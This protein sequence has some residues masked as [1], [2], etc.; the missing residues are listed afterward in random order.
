MSDK[1]QTIDDYKRLALKL[2]PL[3]SHEQDAIVKHLI[4]TDLFFL[5][6]FGCGRADICRQWLLDRCKEVQANPDE[7]LDLWAREHYKDVWIDEL[8]ATPTGFK[9]HGDLCVGDWVYGGDGEPVKVIALSERFTDSECY[10]VTFDDG[11]SVVCGGNHLWEVEKRTRKRKGKG[12]LYREKV[13]LNTKQ[14]ESHGFEADNRLAVKVAPP[15]LNIEH[16]L[17]VDPYV[18]G[19]W[20]GDGHTQAGR[21]TTEDTEVW[22]EVEQAGY[23]TGGTITRGKA[24]TKTC[25]GLSK[26]LREVGV[27]GDKHIPR[28]YLWANERQRRHLLQGLMDSDGHCNTRGTATFVNQNKR[29]I[30]DFEVLC[31]SLGLK[32]RVRKYQGEKKP[33]WQ[34][35]FQAYRNEAPFRL[36]R[37]LDRCKAGKREAKRFIVNVER[38][39]T[40]ET[41]CIQ[42]DAK[43]GLYLV[44]RG[45][46]P[47]HNSTVITFGLTIQEILN[48]PEVT[49]GIFSHSRPIAKGF[50]RQVKRELEANLMLK[51]LFDDVLFQT[52]QKESPKWSE[53]EG[54]VVK[55]K[56]NPKEATLEAWGL[57]DGQPIGKHYKLM[58]YDD[59]VTPASV[60]TPEMIEKTTDAWAMSRSLSTEGG[61]TRYIGTR[62]HFNDTYRVMMMRQSVA[63]RIYPATHD[64]LPD[65]NPVLMSREELA[66]RRRDQGAY[67]F[68]SQMLL[69]PLADETQGF[70]RDWLRYHEGVKDNGGNRYILVDAASGKKKSSDYTAIIVIELGEDN[71]YKVIDLV[72]DRLSLTQRCDLVT[73]FVKKYKPLVVG[74]E[75]YGLMA[76]TEYLRTI[77][78][79]DNYYYSVVE[80][81]GQ[82]PKNDRISRLVPIFEQG[83]MYLPPSR[84]YTG[85]DGI[86][87]DMVETFISEEYEAFPVPLHDDLLD[88]L[89][90]IVDEDLGATFPQS[91]VTDSYDYKPTRRGSAWTA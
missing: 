33:F 35:S 78:S 59:V 75:K 23:A 37:K 42:V 67:V 18:L 89:S 16:I 56:G 9:S 27:F 26:A 85:Y 38:V 72:R 73:R 52:P 91:S 54:I 14:I 8:V 3:P 12:R 53:D 77:M 71:N 6:W 84:N 32:P 60:T 47:T 39:P 17:P 29:L 25:Y 21:I 43:D 5:L 61:R 55:R 51:R 69:N 41:S 86:M 11:E 13:V 62:Y 4:K 74:Y 50:L 24:L 58:I 36:K 49:I 28:A 30:D 64:G 87:R 68:A 7:H 46:I 31:N 10:R 48:N 66:K 44:G 34:V 90:R 1:L 19:Q 83:R 15:L 88:A 80:L 65:G 76:D 57:V 2:N 79:R 40:V 63:V 81:G 82:Q 70:K 20:L 22:Q 45:M